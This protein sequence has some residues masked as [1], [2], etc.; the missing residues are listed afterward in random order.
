MQLCLIC[1]ENYVII[2]MACVL[3]T[4]SIAFKH[5]QVWGTFYYEFYTMI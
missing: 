5:V 2:P 1:A 4:K 3:Y